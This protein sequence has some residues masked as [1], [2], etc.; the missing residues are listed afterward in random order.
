MSDGVKSVRFR[1]LGLVLVQSTPKS[2]RCKC[3]P[4]SRKPCSANTNSQPLGPQLAISRCTPIGFATFSSRR[5]QDLTRWAAFSW[6]KSR[7]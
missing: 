3:V 1:S 5:S 7:A 2:V 6:P 4:P